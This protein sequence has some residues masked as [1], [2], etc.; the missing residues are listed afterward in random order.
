MQQHKRILLL[1]SA[2]VFMSTL[3]SSMLNVALPSIMQVFASPLAL[4]EWVIIIYLLTITVT[5]LFWG[6]LSKK[7]GQA[8]I[9]NQGAFIF[10]IGS[11]LCFLS[12]NIFLLI[13]FRFIQAMGASMMMSMG[14]ALIKAVFPHK[15]LGRGLGQVGIATSLGLMA[16]P[17]ISG[18]LIRWSHWRIIFLITVPVGLAVYFIG[19]NT[20]IIPRRD[21][22]AA[23]DATH[24]TKH[25]FDTIGAMLWTIAVSLTLII[26][27][28]ATSL[29]CSSKSN[30][31]LLL[32][33]GI[34]LT[35]F[36]WFLLTRHELHY[37]FPLLP[38]TLFKKRFYSMAMLCAMLSFTVLFFVLLLTPFYLRSVQ[39]L[40]A[41]QTGY[42]MMALP[43][44]VF[45]ISPIAGWLHDR[46]GARI[47]ATGGL[48]FCLAGLLLLTTIHAETSPLIIA[49]LL[50]LLGFGQAMFLSP[51]SAA[52]LAGV[53][54]Q[55][56][57]V[58]SSLL[59]TARNMGMLVGTALAGLIFTLY[60]S[61]LTGGMDMKDFVPEYTPEFMEALKRSFQAA[62]V[63]ATA[64]MAASWW[65]GKRNQTG[66]N[67]R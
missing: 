2:G 21:K 27:T 33:A 10:S 38:L 31:S 34:L 16:G 66:D 39:Q 56:A 65:R 4:T 45:F 20:Q 49:S 17:A 37:A 35:L 67:A 53:N 6:H 24:H 48:G 8:V 55:Q 12:P 11:L 9:Y 32:I 28:H 44:C 7:Y 25:P 57:G 42:V 51:N 29:C 3:D 46:I 22:A 23:N 60:F 18:L 13:F 54:N 47:V 26:T 63:L 5:L 61:R 58:T 62:S 1:V 50:A 43:L 19:R 36:T 14:P 64:G 52:A 30:G 40:S 15:Q 59:A 41:D